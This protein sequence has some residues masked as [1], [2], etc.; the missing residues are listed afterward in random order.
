MG[1]IKGDKNEN[2]DSLTE[3]ADS[4]YAIASRFNEKGTFIA[5]VAGN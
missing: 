3:N 5:N 2:K 4:E 1:Y